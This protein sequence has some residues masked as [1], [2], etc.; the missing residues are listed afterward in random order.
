MTFTGALGAG[1]FAFAAN[2]AA[3]VQPVPQKPVERASCVPDPNVACPNIYNPVICNGQVYPNSCYADV[4]CA[5]NCHP[6]KGA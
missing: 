2:Q 6:Y 1:T 5:K 4:A 3:P